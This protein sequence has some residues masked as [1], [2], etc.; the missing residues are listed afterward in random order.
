MPYASQDGI[1]IYYEME[2][3]GTPIVLAHGFSM[4]HYDWRDNGYV[5]ELVK[6]HQVIL[7]DGRGHGKS[8]KPHE[9][10]EY[11][12]QLLSADHIAVLDHLGIEAA[13][14]I[15]YSMGGA[16]SFGVALYHSDRCLS[17][18]L[19]GFQP[20]NPE[21]LPQIKLDIEP[22]PVEGLPDTPN[23]IMDI[24][25]NGP[26]AWI[27]F[28]LKNVDTPL[29]MRKRLAANDFQAL[30]AYRLIPDDWKDG[31]RG[32]LKDLGIPCLFLA[33]EKDTVVLGAQE[34]AKVMPNCTFKLL[35]EMNHFDTFYKSGQIIS[36]I[37]K[38]LSKLPN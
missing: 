28:W 30:I 33:G 19:M 25:E 24:L 7:V 2:G 16:T 31:I 21:D 37:E 10:S 6:A 38:F 17:L 14:F 12:T 35:P 5:T 13:H 29:D 8:D 36:V 18:C 11:K 20:F 22:R 32:K 34:A 23:P 15:G 1:N 26:E 4:S 3:H 9:P 27:A